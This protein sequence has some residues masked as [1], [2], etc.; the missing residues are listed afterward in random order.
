MNF[1]YIQKTVCTP[2]PTHIYK[3]I[4]ITCYL[5]WSRYVQVHHLFI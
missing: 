4:L 2:V 1:L 5:H 3:R